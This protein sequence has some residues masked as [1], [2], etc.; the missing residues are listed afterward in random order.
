MIILTCQI[1]VHQIL[2]FLGKKHQHNLN[3]KESTETYLLELCNENEQYEVP[4]W[5]NEF[6]PICVPPIVIKTKLNLTKFVCLF[7]F[8]EM[9]NLYN[10]PQKQTLKQYVLTC[11]N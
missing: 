8:V 7:Q 1:I 6:E 2:L 5:T 3:S 9:K 4:N 11:P 10:Y